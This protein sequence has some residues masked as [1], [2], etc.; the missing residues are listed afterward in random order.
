MWLFSVTY[1]R[2]GHPA[3]GRKIHCEPLNTHNIDRV[4]IDGSSLR[5]MHYF[6]H[7]FFSCLFGRYL[8]ILIHKRSSFIIH[9]LTAPKVSV[10]L[11]LINHTN[12]CYLPASILTCSQ[13]FT[14]KPGE[15]EGFKLMLSRTEMGLR[16]NVQHLQFGSYIT[17]YIFFWSIR[18]SRLFAPQQEASTALTTLP[19]TCSV[20]KG[21]LIK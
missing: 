14:L 3:L 18:I 19:C 21:K 9:S 1:N 2:F 20:R 16:Q 13:E 11:F 7:F 4:G 17:E 10:C 15:W 5:V 12:E 8:K 6:R